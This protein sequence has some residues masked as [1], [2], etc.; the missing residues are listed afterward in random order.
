MIVESG[1]DCYQ[2]LQTG[3]GMEIGPLKVKY[4]N[5]RRT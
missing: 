2:S 1:I 5:A 4:D 3:T